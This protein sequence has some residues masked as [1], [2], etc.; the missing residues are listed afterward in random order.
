M[1]STVP[2]IPPDE[3]PDL[4]PTPVPTLPEPLSRVS[5]RLIDR[6]HHQ[7]ARDQVLQQTLADFLSDPD[8]Q[9][10]DSGPQTQSGRRRLR[11]THDLI[12][13]ETLDF[14]GALKVPLIG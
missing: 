7:L 8:W 5:L 12:Y 14:A 3:T 10:G 2:A 11:L 1:P 13:V 6:L 4:D 9:E